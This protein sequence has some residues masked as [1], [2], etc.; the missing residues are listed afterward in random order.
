M[1]VPDVAA[2]VLV[3]MLAIVTVAMATAGLMG[4]IGA[5]TW[6]QCARCGRITPVSAA[7]PPDSC[8]YCRQ[9][10]SAD[11]RHPHARMS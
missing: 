10:H 2:A 4:M 7:A 5:L 9:T 11:L 8:I 1:P 3:G 6:V